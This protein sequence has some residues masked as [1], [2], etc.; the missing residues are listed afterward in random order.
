M[1]IKIKEEVEE[2]EKT[3]SHTL[4]SEKKLRKKSLQEMNEETGL[5]H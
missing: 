5:P 4:S 2:E 1:N 3:P